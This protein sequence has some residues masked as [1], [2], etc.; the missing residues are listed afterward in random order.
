MAFAPKSVTNILIKINDAHGWEDMLKL[1]ETK[2]VVVDAH[3]DWCGLCE[4][5]L[6]TMSRILIDYESAESRFSY[7]SIDRNLF[8]DKIQKTI[9]RDKGVD[10]SSMG[11]TPMFL[12]YKNREVV[13]IVPGVDTP[14]LLGHIRYLKHSCCIWAEFKKR[15]RSFWKAIHLQCQTPRLR[16][17][18]A[19]FSQL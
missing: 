11:C 17:L 16:S 10:I 8:A 4:A 2:L 13:A 7:Q 12:C 6:P 14:S 3:A 18:C 9:P 15:S 5:I 19:A 1:S